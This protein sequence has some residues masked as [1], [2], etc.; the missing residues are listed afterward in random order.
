MSSKWGD[1]LQSKL[2]VLTEASSKE[3][4]Q[5]IAMWMWFNRKH[6]AAFVGVM[7]DGL[8]NQSFKSS[9]VLLSVLHEVFMLHLKQADK[10]EAAADMRSSLAESLLVRYTGTAIPIAKV[11][12][13]LPLWDTHNVFSGPTLINQIRKQIA[14]NNSV[15][16]NS[17]TN[18]N[19]SPK[20]DSAISPSI[21]VEAIPKSQLKIEAISKSQSPTEAA[22]VPVELSVKQEEVPMPM[23]NP[24]NL[25]VDDTDV[26]NPRFLRTSSVSLASSFSS[27]EVTYDFEATGVAAATIDVKD[28]IEPCRNIATLQI[29]RDLLGDGA[30]QLSSMLQSMPESVRTFTAEHAEQQGSPATLTDAQAREFCAIVSD[31]LL[32]LD[33]SEQLSNV[34]TLR[35]L[36]AKQQMARMRLRETLLASRCQFGAEEAAAAYYAVDDTEL[37]DRAQIL[38]DAMDL[39][40]LEVQPVVLAAMDAETLEPFSWYLPPGTTEALMAD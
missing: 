27:K 10:W 1:K 34:Q 8:E 28:L 32:D 26:F 22:P 21:K 16:T 40:G 9:A 14:S 12:A 35:N 39:E 6:T 2:S 3:S 19:S 33:L 29:A 24:L 38:A 7:R 11:Q 5:S 4:L 18:S 31:P 36:V 23:L 17:H 13:L 25:A 30:V 15:N 20:V 37:K